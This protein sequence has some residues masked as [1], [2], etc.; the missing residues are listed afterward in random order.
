MKQAPGQLWLVVTHEREGERVAVHLK[1]VSH[2][3]KNLE[4]YTSMVLVNLTEL[5][6]VV[7]KVKRKSLE[8]R[9]IME[10]S[11]LAAHE[12]ALLTEWPKGAPAIVA[13]FEASPGRG[14]RRQYS[15][16]NL[17]NFLVARELGGFGLTVGRIKYVLEQ[18]KSLMKQTGIRV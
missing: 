17:F 6:R 1:L 9:H 7:S 18:L 11:K 4:K 3:P 13:E 16:L 2:E 14:E 15:R 10:H 8:R 5:L 12:V